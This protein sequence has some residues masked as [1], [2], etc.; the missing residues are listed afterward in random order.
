[1]DCGE[2]NDDCHDSLFDERIFY[3]IQIQIFVLFDVG[4]RNCCDLFRAD[5]YIELFCLHISNLCCLQ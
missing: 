3:L 4:G 2:L 5:Q 1:M